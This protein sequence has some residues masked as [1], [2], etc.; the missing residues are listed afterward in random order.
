MPD[1]LQSAWMVQAL[2]GQTAEAVASL[3]TRFPEM[4]VLELEESVARFLASLPSIEADSLLGD[5]ER[6]ERIVAIMEQDEQDSEGD[7][8][9][10]I[11]F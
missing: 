9:A 2:T 6:V 7:I 3:S 4:T 10:D 11:P 1:S 8:G 5:T